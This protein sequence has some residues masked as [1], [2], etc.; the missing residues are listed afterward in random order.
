MVTRGENLV[1]CIILAHFMHLNHKAGIKI[2][3]QNTKKIIIAK[4]FW[5][6]NFCALVSLWQK[7]T[8]PMNY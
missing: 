1:P 6:Y 8:F 7:V 2:M 3:S 4:I 5:L